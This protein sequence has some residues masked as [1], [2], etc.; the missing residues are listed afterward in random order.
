[1]RLSVVV[2]CLAVHVLCA[3]AAGFRK[4]YNSSQPAAPAAVPAASPVASPAPATIVVMAPSPC[5]PQPCIDIG[6]KERKRKRKREKKA[7][8]K[9]EE[10]AEEACEKQCNAVKDEVKA[11]KKEQEEQKKNLEKAVEEGTKKIEEVVKKQLNASLSK[12]EA[13]MKE[14][15]KEVSTQLK[16]SRKTNHEVYNNT[17]KSSISLEGDKTKDLTR[18]LFH[19]ALEHEL[20]LAE[21]VQHVVWRQGLAGAQEYSVEESTKAGEELSASIDEKLHG[22]WKHATERSD[23]AVKVAEGAVNSILEIWASSMQAAQNDF[24]KIAKAYSDAN[25]GA[26]MA[27]ES[28][29]H[30]LSAN[31]VTNL[32]MDTAVVDKTRAQEALDKAGTALN[33][34]KTRLQVA[35]TN[36]G[37]LAAITE[38]VDAAAGAAV[39]ATDASQT[40]VLGANEMAK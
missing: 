31:Q 8:E 6:R 2:V 11:A 33:A 9:A 25:M 26:H 7:I 17:I 22:S 18:H 10:E 19:D 35:T 1:M 15:A 34:A 4:K 32:L 12:I 13:D 40:L 16:V 24:N 38:K 39:R 29:V 27:H 30:L 14:V 37:K 5:P 21:Q 28:V 3:R 36:K 20:G 23:N